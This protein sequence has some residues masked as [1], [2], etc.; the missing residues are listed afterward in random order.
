MRQYSSV[1]AVLGKD[2]DLM[3]K[4][5]LQKAVEQ[6]VQNPVMAFTLGAL[7]G[8]VA[9]ML[10]VPF[11]KGIVILSHNGSY[12]KASHEEGDYISKSENE[13]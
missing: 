1:C 4:C 8:L 11:S 9:G 12:N 13:D 3:K 2:I 6:A 5:D 7:C 10:L